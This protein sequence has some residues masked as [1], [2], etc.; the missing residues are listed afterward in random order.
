VGRV[1][2]SHRARSA[3]PV[4]IA[5]KGEPMKAFAYVLVAV[6]MVAGVA[7]GGDDNSSTPQETGGGGVS[8]SLSITLKEAATAQEVYLTS[9]SSYAA[10][11][12]DLDFT[13]EAG[14]TLTV[15]DSADDSYCME[16]TD[17]TATAHI[18]S[19]NLVPEEG[20]C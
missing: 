13:A 1:R 12:N 3:N 20:A 5:R 17:D 2:E 15:V 6:V 9:N 11:V 16:A 19:D 18:S 4:E 7:C 14:T 8:D 10:D